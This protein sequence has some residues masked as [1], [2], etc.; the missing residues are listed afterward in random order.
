MKTTPSMPVLPL[1]LQLL[2]L[3]LILCCVSASHLTQA[4]EDDPHWFEVIRATPYRESRG[5]ATNL[6]TVRRWVLFGESYCENDER[7]LLLDRR[8]RFL[9]Y[10]DNTGSA[11]G[12]LEKLNA[13]RRRLASE[14][15]VETW[16]PGADGSR[17]YPFALSCYQPFVDMPAA[18]ARLTGSDPDH[19]LWG[20]WDGMRIGEPDAPVSLINLFREVY[21]NRAAQDLFSFPDSM[22]PVFLGK[23]IIESAGQKNALSSRA[24]RGILQL[25]PAV[26]DDCR[27]PEA[28]RLHRIA[29][30]DC[31]LRLV[32]QNHRNL[33]EPF[34]AVFGH[35]PPD[36]Q[37]S[38]YALLLTQ[39]Y[40]I[41]VGRSLELLQD[42][43]LGRAAAYFAE[44]H[45]DFSAE[46]ILIGM[47]YH[48]IGRRDIGLLTLYYVTD[49]GLA[50]D[51]LC[52]DPGMAGD[53]W[54]AERR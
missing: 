51:A 32:E 48:N 27:I 4:A 8:W 39:A 7:H 53:P 34:E 44:H 10:M 26:L 25:R 43:E 20:T 52:R 9:G 40:Q 42:E 1:L 29:Q 18:I 31:A 50:L 15:R 35:L 11:E 13:E 45:A 23:I 46:E 24:A 12:N 30:V 36:K 2:Q 47:I 37:L 54:C 38:L 3:L 41:G 49:S 33:R 21:E 5:V 22:I 17:G 6:G 16:H 28:F 14:G 19:R